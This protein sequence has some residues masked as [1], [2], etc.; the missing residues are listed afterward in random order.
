MIQADPQE[1]RVLLVEDD[2]DD[3]LITRD[4]L[5]R[6]QR[7]RF[8]VDW[9]SDFDHALAVISEERHDA[10]LVDYR[11][12]SRNGLDLV[13]D[14]FVARSKA[15]VIMLTGQ[16]DYAIDLEA[17]ALGVT[18]FL[19]KHELNPDS[20]ER[21]L[22]YAINHHR[23]LRDLAISEERYALA[24]CAANDGIWDWD[25][26]SDRV[27]YSPRWQALLGISD[28][29]LPAR[30]LGPEEWF[31]RV[32]EDDLPGLRLAIEAHLSGRTSLL[33]SKH[34]VRHA[35]GTW[36]WVLTRG[37]AVRNTDGEPSRM[38]GSLS[39]ITISRRT[40]RQLQ[41]DALH[42]TLT[43][44]P[45]R[46]LFVDRVERAMMRHRRDPSKGCAILFLDIDRFKLVNDTFSHTI[47][48][49]LLVALAA[50]VVSEIHPED[51][52]ARMAGD[53]FTLLLDGIP[54]DQIE[55]RA[56]E[57]AASVGET[58]REPFNIDG[59]RLFVTAS[60]GIG[61][62]TVDVSA[63][64]LIRNA[65]IAMYEAKH[66]DSGGCLVFDESMHRRISDRLSRQNDLREVIEG[67]LLQVY[68]QPVLD[69]GSGRIHGFEAL[70]RWPEGWPALSPAE[71][72]PIAEETG[73]ITPLG[74]HVLRT[75]LG[76][77]ASWR[78]GGLVG[79]EVRMSV[80]VSG[81]QLD[82]PQF[83][84][85]VIDIIASTGVPGSVVRLEITE[86]TLMREPE[87]IARIV[88][89]V[90]STG[91]GLELDDFGTGYSSLSALHQ[92]PVNALKIDHS[93]VANLNAEE[94]EVLVRSTVALAHSLGLEVVAEGI[95]TEHE[96]VR[97]RSLGCEY[98]QGFLFSPPLP[99]DRAEKFLLERSA[100]MIPG[101]P[102]GATPPREHSRA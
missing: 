12:G 53:E 74:L 72:I 75:A 67:G 80:N 59:H 32:H 5:E 49:W 4:F 28:E 3:F 51:T 63:A 58:L 26:Q 23:A 41:H 42:D 90:C 1:V 79:P 10:Y 36:R 8:A 33:Q 82:D 87:R 101:N 21:A 16:S 62:P 55:S 14:G 35:D 93:F 47:G 86:G 44:L 96:L 61:I 98:G 29:L 17:S 81:R 73:L 66:R 76:A 65:D 83:P 56:K 71:F 18:D 68:Y 6:Q 95:E 27:Y 2:E 46:A 100:D 52:V 48:D 24:A 77:L 11:L 64:D 37:M 45:N 57:V 97:L 88:S 92:F 70:A 25:L 43:G 7:V 40:E 78:S 60:I 9:S 31:D 102:A 69:L 30:E 20:L 89:E 39:D 85:D 19:L 54:T 38:A 13:R 50:R 91:V 34:R 15:P 84:E 94:G 99:R 22:R